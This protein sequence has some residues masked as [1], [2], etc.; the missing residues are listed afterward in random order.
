LT[1]F[2][3]SQHYGTETYFKKQYHLAERNKQSLVLVPL[4]PSPPK[5]ETISHGPSKSN[6]SQNLKPRSFA[7][8]SDWETMQEGH[9]LDLTD[10]EHRR[11]LARCKNELETEIHFQKKCLTIQNKDSD[12]VQRL[13]MELKS[14]N[15]Q[16]DHVKSSLDS[17]C[18]YCEDTS[19]LSETESQR[20]QD[21]HIQRALLLY[22]KQQASGDIISLAIENM[23]KFS[24]QNASQ[25]ATNKIDLNIH[26]KERHV[27]TLFEA[28]L[29]IKD[30]VFSIP[31]LSGLG[32]TV[33]STILQSQTK[34]PWYSKRNKRV[35]WRAEDSP[36]C[37]TC[38]EILQYSMDQT[39]EQD[40]A[41]NKE[42]FRINEVVYC[43]LA[44]VQDRW[45]E[46][47]CEQPDKM[48]HDNALCY[49]CKKFLHYYSCGPTSFYFNDFIYDGNCKPSNRVPECNGQSCQMIR[50]NNIMFCNLKCAELLP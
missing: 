30:P 15:D 13:K 39:Q 11:E 22:N 28:I 34:T 20:H 3:E 6:Y 19:K 32:T 12:V 17:K 47:Q 31:S 44:C 26:K 41:Y 16:Y 21:Y 18:K 29:D 36:R 37:K 33:P 42:A 1:Y 23:K 46:I 14:I 2:T 4:P 38:R 24:V 5:N 25:Q 40:W 27:Q 10:K 7:V 48:E 45:K 49:Q 50:V 8:V 35:K 43:S 9:I